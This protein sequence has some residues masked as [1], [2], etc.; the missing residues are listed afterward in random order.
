VLS[1]PRKRIAHYRPMATCLALNPR[2]LN[3]MLIGYEGGV[4]AWDFQKGVA[5]KNFEMFLPPGAPGGGSYQNNDVGPAM[6]IADFRPSGLSV[7]HQSPHSP[8]VQ[9]VKSLRSVTRT[10]VSR[11]GRTRSRTSR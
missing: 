7:L 4:V 6:I 10:A 2:D 5:V 1:T 3:I 9:T 11:S 8:G